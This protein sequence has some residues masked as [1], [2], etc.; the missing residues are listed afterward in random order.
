MKDPKNSKLAFGINLVS[1]NRTGDTKTDLE[2]NLIARRQNDIPRKT[3]QVSI[4]EIDCSR[5]KIPQPNKPFTPDMFTCESMPLPNFPPPRKMSPKEERIQKELKRSRTASDS[6][7]KKSPA[8][9]VA[10]AVA[11]EIFKLL[12]LGVFIALKYTVIAI[13]LFITIGCAICAGRQT[14]ELMVEKYRW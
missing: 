9:A 3:V 4:P 6:F 5:S 11:W 8:L 2:R 14:R 13:F 7:T 10:A 12:C 1:T